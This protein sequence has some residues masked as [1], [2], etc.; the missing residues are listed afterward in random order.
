MKYLEL[1]KKLKEFVV[2]SVSD[3]KKIDPSSNCLRRIYEWQ[4]KGYIKKIIKGHYIFSDLE[5]N[6]QI[7]FIL[8]NKIYEPS[9]IS[10][11]IALSYYR[12]I[13]ESVYG[14]TS[15]TSRKTSHFK[16][17]LAEFYYHSVKPSLMFG[18]KLIKYQDQVFKI[19]E[20]E[21]AFLDYLYIKPHIKEIKDF[22]GLRIDKQNFL[23]QVSKEKINEYLKIIDST[24]LSRR[25]RKFM[26]YMK[27]A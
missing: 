15:A 19:A 9:Y 14:I 4:E 2:F 12:L 24:V 20:V 16:T 6:E 17:H 22:E 21:K 23:E 10:F 26:R 1:R 27:N 25:V 5:L 8:A 13:P 11:E 3:V 18:Y 7:F